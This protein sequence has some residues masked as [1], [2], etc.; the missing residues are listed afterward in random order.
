MINANQESP[1]FTGTINSQDVWR[2]RYYVA[3]VESNTIVVLRSFNRE[4][5]AKSLCKELHKAWY[6]T[7][8]VDPS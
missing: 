2:V 8:Y 3:V 5:D 7:R 6:A 1:F 4:D